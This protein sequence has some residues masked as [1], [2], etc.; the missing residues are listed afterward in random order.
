VSHRGKWKGVDVAVERFNYQKANR[1]DFQAG[2]AALLL[3]RHPNVV[4]FI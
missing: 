2:M 4:L 1:R 3:L